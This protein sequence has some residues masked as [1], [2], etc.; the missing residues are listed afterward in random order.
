M[1]VRRSRRKGYHVLPN[2]QVRRREDFGDLPRRLDDFHTRA[3][4][5]DISQL[6]GSAA[7][8]ERLQRIVGLAAHVNSAIA[9]YVDQEEYPGLPGGSSGASEVAAGQG[10][11]EP[12]VVILAVERGLAFARVV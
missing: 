9:V 7:D 3:H 2:A 8:I 5:V 12:D 10:V 6:K 1:P 11:Y 4:G